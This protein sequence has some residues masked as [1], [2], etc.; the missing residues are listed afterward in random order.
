MKV[1]TQYKPRIHY[2]PR[3]G[4]INDPNG[5]SYYDNKYHLFA[6][7]YPHDSVW[8]P[9]HWS[10]A[11]SE[12]LITWEH[13]D[14]ALSPDMEYDKGGCF[15]GS[16][17]KIDGKHILY[18]TSVEKNGNQQQSMAIGDGEKYEKY[19]GNP[20]L[21][22]DKLPDK[23]IQGEFRDP[24]VFI[25]NNKYYMLLGT[26]T[27][28]L[29]GAIIV[30]ISKNG[31]D[32]EFLNEV[33]SS[34]ECEDGV[35]ECPDLITIDD[36]DILIYSPINKSEEDYKYLNVSST[37]YE[38]GKFNLDSGKFVSEYKDELD[39]GFDYYAPQVYNYDGK[40]HI[41][42]W[43]QMWGKE[44]PTNTRQHG[45]SG[46]MTLPRELELNDNKL[47]IK[48]PNN[49][50]N[51]LGTQRHINSEGETLKICGTTVVK[52]TGDAIVGKID[53]SNQIDIQIS[54]NQ[55]VL[56]RERI[57]DLVKSVD[58]GAP[59][60]TS[61]RIENVKVRDLKIVIDKSSVELFINNMYTMTTTFYP[62]QTS[63]NIQGLEQS[64]IGIFDVK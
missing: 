61:R 20:I 35:Y 47:E 12:D 15:S 30:Y 63:L 57:A 4:W 38:V 62:E 49:L 32:W 26:K 21:T 54:D 10:H 59:Q 13:L 31:Y 6:Q 18:Y 50:D 60:Y 51:Y 39:F 46:Q 37:V 33:I 40:H 17:I 25:R 11:V 7:H 45:W 56:N 19:S 58:E 28:D 8:G 2:A 9:M 44:I 36:K 48:Y 27:K 16:A 22:S 24:K 42:A 3:Q 5:I 23:Y 53:I 34:T 41:V 14:I 1:D 55:I 29:C 64:S 52:I 43:M